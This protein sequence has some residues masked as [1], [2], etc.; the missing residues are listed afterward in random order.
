MAN[1]KWIIHP[2]ETRVIDLADIEFLKAGLAAGQ[3]DVIGHDEDHVRVEV[4]SV[5]VKELRIEVTGGQL[6]IDHP[7]VRWDN[8][9]TAFKNFGSSGPR[10]EISVAV[11][12]GVRLELGVVSAG[13]LVAG[14]AASA[15]INTVSG[16]VLVD[17]LTGDLN[18][19]AV[20]GDIQVRGLAGSFSADAVSSD[21]AAEGAI[22]K[23]DVNTVSGAVSIDATGPIGRVDVNTVSGASTLRL[24]EGYAANYTTHTIS[25]RTSVDGVSRSKNFDGHT[26]ELAGVF[27][28][29]RVNSVSGDVMV[30]R[31]GSVDTGV[32][33]DVEW[34]GASTGDER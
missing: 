6:E 20:S 22:T 11:P 2:G 21:V 14:L 10:A 27:A 31:R 3:I 5:A 29:V 16:D 18:T 32:D 15:V 4:H 34:P 9:L 19:H 17:G 13:A 33:D 28:D 23:A 26:G 24:D 12:R 25:G 30:L 7:Q 8:F 1:E